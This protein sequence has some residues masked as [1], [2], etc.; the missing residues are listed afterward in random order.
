MIKSYYESRV[1]TSREYFIVSY[2]KVIVMIKFL[3]FGMA[4]GAGLMFS[5]IQRAEA[6]VIQPIALPTD[7]N[8]ILQA[9]YWHRYG[10]H[11]GYYGHHYRHY[12]YRSGY[13]YGYWGAPVYG[14]ICAQE[15]L[16][17]Y[18]AMECD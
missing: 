1:L 18:C 15:C 8:N 3:I 10:H 9:Q 16:G 7:Q 4:L 6:V 5:A 13:P 17:P 11:Y 12:G 14:P 2:L